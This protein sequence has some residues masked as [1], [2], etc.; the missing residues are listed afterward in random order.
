MIYGTS[1][2]VTAGSIQY[3]VV[4]LVIIKYDYL[5]VVTSRSSSYSYDFLFVVIKYLWG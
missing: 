2:C 3:Q 1:D 5:G 4:A